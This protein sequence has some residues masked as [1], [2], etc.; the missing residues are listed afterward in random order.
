MRRRVKRLHPA[1]KRALKYP[2]NA[3]DSRVLLDWR[4]R[5]RTVCKP[6]WELKYCPY[7]PLVE[8][9]PL[10]PLLRSE[11]EEHDEYLRS[12]LATG[13]LGDG[14]PLDSARRR[15]FQAELRRSAKEDLP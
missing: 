6:C 10:P 1:V 4:R 14:R 5:T 13:R 3:P 11:A 7:G 12:C 2:E 15:S 9:F 8:D